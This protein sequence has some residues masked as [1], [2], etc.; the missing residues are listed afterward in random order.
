MGRP[1]ICAEPRVTMAVRLPASLRDELRAAALARDVSV[2]FLVNRA[3]TDYLARL[4]PLGDHQGPLV[5]EAHPLTP[6]V[7]W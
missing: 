7:A 1:K 2:N 3:V 4:A 5:E 6:Q